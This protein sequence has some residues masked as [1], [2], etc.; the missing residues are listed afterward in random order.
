MIGRMTLNKNKIKKLVRAWENFKPIY[1]IAKELNIS[2]TLAYNWLK[3]NGYDVNLG[4]TLKHRSDTIKQK[5]KKLYIEQGYTQQKI[6]KKLKLSDV[7]VRKYLNELRK[8]GY[9]E[10]IRA[11]KSRN[12]RRKHGRK[13]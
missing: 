5:I 11:A 6:A 9:E 2:H 10:Q 1:R 12:R 3:E 13:R 7:I 4:R 8:E